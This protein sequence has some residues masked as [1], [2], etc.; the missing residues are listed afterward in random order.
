MKCARP[1]RGTFPVRIDVIKIMPVDHVLAVNARHFEK[2]FVD[3]QRTELL[4]GSLDIDEFVNPK[5][6]VEWVNMRLRLRESQCQYKD[7]AK[8]GGYGRNGRPLA[9]SFFSSFSVQSQLL[10]DHGSVPLISLQR[11]RA[12]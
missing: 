6:E 5:L 10:H 2:R 8:H 12:C 9:A 7:R 1:R 11:L 4:R 3:F